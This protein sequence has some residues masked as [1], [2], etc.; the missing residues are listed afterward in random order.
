MSKPALLS[1]GPMMSLIDEGIDRAF[2]VHRLHQAGDPE[3]LLQ[4]VGPQIRAIC[5]GSHT[6]VKTDAAMMG[7]CPI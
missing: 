5:T 3:A 1:T 2:L 7:H 4:K 6:G